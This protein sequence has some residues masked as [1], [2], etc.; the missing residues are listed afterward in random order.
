MHL[1]ISRKVFEQFVYREECQY[2]GWLNTA[3]MEF[4]SHCL[5]VLYENQKYTKTES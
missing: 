2:T 5:I 1:Y 4:C 3:D